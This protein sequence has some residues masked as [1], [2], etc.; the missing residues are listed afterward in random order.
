MNPLQTPLLV[1]G[2][3]CEAAFPEYEQYFNEAYRAG[4]VFDR[5]GRR[6]I[7]TPDRAHHVC[8]ANPRHSEQ[9]VKSR[10]VWREDRAQRIPWIMVALTHPTCQLKENKEPGMW[11]YLI[12]MQITHPA[13]ICNYYTVVVEPRRNGEEVKFVSAYRIDDREWQNS[14]K[15]KSIRP[16]RIKREAGDTKP[17]IS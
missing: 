14:I 16:P 15:M 8:F 7:F 13:M 9:K 10:P 11:N 3:C 5:F 4:P 6:V 12:R 1:L 2:T 17:P